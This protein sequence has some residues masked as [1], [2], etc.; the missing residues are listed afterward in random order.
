M[1]VIIN[2]Y[3]IDSQ[4]DTI[5]DFVDSLVRNTFGV[6]KLLENKENSLLKSYMTY[7]KHITKDITVNMFLSS[8]KF[9]GFAESSKL[10]NLLIQLTDEPYWQDSLQTDEAANYQCEN[11]KEFFK[12]KPNCLTEALERD[13]VILSFE[14]KAFQNTCISIFKNGNAT[15][16]YNLY[17]KNNAAKKLFLIGEI[18]F[19]DYLLSNIPV[20][21]IRVLLYNK[22]SCYINEYYDNRDLSK[23][24][25]ITIKEDFDLFVAGINGQPMFPR[26]T[27]SI[28]YKG[29]TYNEFR[30]T[31]SNNREYRIFYKLDNR[32]VI[33]FNTLIKK[34]QTTPNHI[35]QQTY[36]LIKNYDN[37]K[38]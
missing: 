29:I 15:E 4:F 8:Q 5:D 1:E 21:S 6:L 17:N 11:L 10:K 3:S 13:K 14:H 20:S 28:T 30:T 32:V 33:L 16:I 35:K 18:G 19:A 23:E 9:M 12:D 37:S 25:V 34:T 27:D 7:D 38:N 36:D 26:L 2:D 31:I 22:N 24:D